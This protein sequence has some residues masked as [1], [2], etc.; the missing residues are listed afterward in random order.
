MSNE[1]CR[2]KKSNRH[3]GESTDVLILESCPRPSIRM[4]SAANIVK[5]LDTDGNQERQHTAQPDGPDP[6]I[7]KRMLSE[8]ISH[9]FRRSAKRQN[10][11]IQSVLELARAR[12]LQILQRCVYEN[13]PRTEVNVRSGWKTTE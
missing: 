5:Y 2:S 11:V 6:I 12:R 10:I 9:Q 7:G 3:N 13:N 1:A 8:L 4:K